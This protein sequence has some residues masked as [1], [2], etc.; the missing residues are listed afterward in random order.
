MTDTSSVAAQALSWF[1][2][3]SLVVAAANASGCVSGASD[4]SDET[5]SSGSVVVGVTSDLVPGVDIARVRATSRADGRV[6]RDQTL[7]INDSAAPLVF[8]A[9]FWFSGLPDKTEVELHV[10]AFVNYL[11][12]GEPLL[13]R[14]AATDIVAGHTLLQRAR[15]ERECIPS[16]RLTNDLIAP[17][18]SSPETCVT[19]A[20]TSPYLPSARLEEYTPTWADSFAD[21][22]KPLD[23]GAPIVVVGE[24]RDVYKPLTSSSVV[25]IEAGPQGGYHIWLA[26]QMK[27]LH[28]LGSRTTVELYPLGSTEPLG[29]FVTVQSYEP[30]SSGSCELRGLRC[31]LTLYKGDL[32]TVLGKSIR[33]TVKVADV[34]DDVGVGEQIITLSNDF[35]K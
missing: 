27:N 7:R 14:D 4:A 18:C 23:S 30:V 3:V 19:A 2:S 10:E 16:A 29:T 25:Q 15:L 33:A 12:G 35:V 28:R 13:I 24:G 17:T 11:P 34:V 6:L 26:V 1:S 22:C 31:Q 5:G 9:E 20:C 8:P 21:E 32:A